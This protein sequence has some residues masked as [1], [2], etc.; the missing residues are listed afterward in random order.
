MMALIERADP[1]FAARRRGAGAV[2]SGFGSG[3]G[4]GLGSA[5]GMGAGV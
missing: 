1:V 5:F 4:S 2:A 3:F